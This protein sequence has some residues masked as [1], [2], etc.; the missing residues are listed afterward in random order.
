MIVAQKLSTI[1]GYKIIDLYLINATKELEWCNRHM[2][3]FQLRYGINKRNITFHWTRN[4][5]AASKLKA[6]PSF[7]TSVDYW[8]RCQWQFTI[9]ISFLSFS[10]KL[11]YLWHKTLLQILQRP[12]KNIYNLP[13]SLIHCYKKSLRLSTSRY[14]CRSSHCHS[15]SSLRIM[16][17]MQ[18]N[19]IWCLKAVETA[20]LY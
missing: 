3:I 7:Y 12:N 9:I 4:S 6:E 20:V 2:Y 19:K 14:R 11:L 5:I 15:A 13:Y 8:Y 10:L 17:L 16:I 18:R 1:L